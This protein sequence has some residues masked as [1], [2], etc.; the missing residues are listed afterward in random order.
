[1]STTS[2]K[3]EYIV[4]LREQGK[5]ALATVLKNEQNIRVIEK[6]IHKKA[7]KKSNQ[8]E[9]EETDPEEIYKV[10]YRRICYQTVGGIL[11]GD[12]VQ[13]LLT[14]IKKEET[15][16]NHPIYSDVKYRIEEHDEFIINPFEVEEGVTE[17]NK[18][19]SKRVFTYQKQCRAS[20][21][22]ATTFAQCVQ[23]KVKWTY[24]G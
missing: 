18:C 23:C 7:V 14:N 19:G 1:M 21:E 5:L 16:W 22:S 8:E 13:E 11:K 24:S 3:K 10:T 2:E 6:Y 20:D 12:K 17:C 4:L 9:T 15:G